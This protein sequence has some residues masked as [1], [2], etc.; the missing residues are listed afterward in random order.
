LEW[1]QQLSDKLK[2][3]ANLSY[4]DSEDTRTP[5]GSTATPGGMA[6]WLGNLS[7][8]ARPQRNLLFTSHLYHVG[9]R[10][11]AANDVDGY[12]RLDL[13]LSALHLATKGLTVRA[14]VKN[15][16]DDGVRYVL[17]LPTGPVVNI[18]DGRTWWLQLKYEL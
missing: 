6:K 18:H 9:E 13:S 5:D 17:N 15:A 7:L 8:I 11:A 10:A 1:E 2:W 12:S 14:S 4:V 16:L 3:S